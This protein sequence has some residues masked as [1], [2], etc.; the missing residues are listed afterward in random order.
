MRKK[1][2]KQKKIYSQYI[3]ERKELMDTTNFK[4]QDIF[5]DVINK[6]NIPPDQKIKPNN[7]LAKML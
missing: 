2:Y 3:D 6:D 5:A 1:H 4:V 7:F